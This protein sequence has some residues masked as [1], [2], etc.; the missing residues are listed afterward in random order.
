MEKFGKWDILVHINV[1]CLHSTNC[2]GQRAS[3]WLYPEIKDSIYVQNYNK[4]KTQF[5]CRITDA[6]LS[7]VTP[8][9]MIQFLFMDALISSFIQPFKY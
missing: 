6:V 3:I 9:V 2:L 4:G 7:G 5:M 8:D 1:Y